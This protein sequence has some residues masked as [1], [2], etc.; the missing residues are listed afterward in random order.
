MKSVD[1]LVTHIVSKASFYREITLSNRDTKT[2]NSLYETISSPTYITE[3]QGNLCLQIL[4]QDYIR[5]FFNPEEL[6]ILDNPVWEHPFRII[7]E[8]R[9]IY[10]SPTSPI[11]SSKFDGNGVIVIE[12]SFSSVIRTQLQHLSSNIIQVR[13][14]S[15]YIADYTE[16]NI[17]LIL[18]TL[19]EYKF[20]V[21][22]KIQQYYDTICSWDEKEIK[23]RFLSANLNDNFNKIFSKD[24]D[25]TNPLLLIDRRHR[26]QYTDNYVGNCNTLTETIA[27]RPTTKL[28]V[29][30]RLHPLSNLVQ[31]LIEL[32][33]TPILF[34]FDQT[35]DFNTIVQF[36]EISHALT[37]NN[38]TDDIGVYF[39]LDNTPDGKIFNDV[40]AK[41]K[42]NCNL[43]DSTQVACVRAGK[44]PKFFLK[45]T[46]KPMSI[47][48]INN[49]LRQ[50]KTAIYAKCCDL[51]IT[52]SAT[53]P[54]I[55][56]RNTWELN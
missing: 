43:S 19:E 3:K 51:V 5:A 28:W 23:N 11:R 4:N 50:S 9:K 49:T 48:S 21:D 53:E 26:Y 41:R 38:I 20:E 31:S 12:F 34:V 27:N 10:F 42:Y 35:T 46:W 1:E 7:P 39:R 33:R 22:P 52:Y 17:F 47:I 8:V 24:I 18:K 56:T 6:E 45:E 32:K 25:N 44:L 13:S 15:L 30:S 2:I 29:N 40:I 37:T 16:K 14:G 55:E 36:N 54:L